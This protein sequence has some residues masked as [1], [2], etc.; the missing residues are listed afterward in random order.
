MKFVA[1]TACP[2]GVAHTYMAAEALEMAAEELGHEIKVETQGSMGVENELTPEE[3]A[4]ADAVIFAVDMSV[5]RSERFAGKLILKKGVSEAIK[6]S[7]EIILAAVELVE[8]GGDLSPQV[9]SGEPR[10]GKPSSASSER[11][12]EENEK[13]K[14]LFGWLKRK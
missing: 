3:I 14:V 13:R 1:V 9:D 2:T 5:T 10:S 7:R 4:A 6:H 12:K 11:G 8:K